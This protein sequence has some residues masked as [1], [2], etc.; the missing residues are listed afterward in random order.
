MAQTYPAPGCGSTY[1][2]RAPKAELAKG[3]QCKTP[4]HHTSGRQAA[5]TPLCTAFSSQKQVKHQK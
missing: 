4:K 3:T 1:Q 5:G 2:H